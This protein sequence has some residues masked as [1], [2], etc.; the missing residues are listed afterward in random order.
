MKSWLLT[1]LAIALALMAALM[2]NLAYAG[3]TAREVGT[4]SKIVTN[5]PLTVFNLA[6][7]ARIWLD[8]PSMGL[9]GN[10]GEYSTGTLLNLIRDSAF[11]SGRIKVALVSDQV[12]QKVS[13]KA[14]LTGSVDIGEE[15][16]S[17]LFFIPKV[18]LALGK[19]KLVAKTTLVLTVY[20]M[21]TGQ[22]EAM[23]KA[24]GRADKSLASNTAIVIGRYAAGQGAAKEV[25]EEEL[26]RASLAQ[27]AT[28]LASQLPSCTLVM[29]ATVPKP[30]S[31][32]STRNR[33]DYDDRSNRSNPG[34]DYT[35]QGLKP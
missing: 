28:L 29:P 19:D 17:G 25:S 3:T 9:G 7:E 12:K 24:E 1:N 26:V 34:I 22:V 4:L 35:R 18:G 32:A 14:I 6:P 11:A 27:A 16:K 8:E 2:P 23:V 13:H 21:T 15:A 33:N 10:W 5:L 30:T 31:I 20:N